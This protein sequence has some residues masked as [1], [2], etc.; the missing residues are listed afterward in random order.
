[1]FSD[2]ENRNHQERKLMS[3]TALNTDQG[4]LHFFLAISDH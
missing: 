4:A 1:M 3:T 2:F